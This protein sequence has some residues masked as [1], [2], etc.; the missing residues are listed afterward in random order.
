MNNP[1]GDITIQLLNI[2][3]E[4]GFC[5]EQQ[6]NIKMSKFVVLSS[7]SFFLE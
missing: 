4:N 1:S 7:A 2:F 6:I 3:G 5:L